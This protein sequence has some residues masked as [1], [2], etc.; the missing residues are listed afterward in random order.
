LSYDVLIIGGA[1]AGLTAA[2]YA[3]RQGLKTLVI[4]KDIGGQA[5][6]TNAIENYP[7]FE[8]IGGFELM[9]KFEQQARNFGTEFAYEEVLSITEHKEDNGNSGFIIKTN[10]DDNEYSGH[11]LI[12]AFGKTPRDLNVKGEKEL[13]GRGVSYCA[14][15][16]GPFFKN[17]KVAIVGAGDQ[18]LEAA[19]YLKEL[20]SQLYI[21]HS[22]DQPVGSEES[23]DLLLQNKHNNTNKK[24]SFISNSI[25]KA[26]NG[27]SK[28][29]SLT[30]YDS[31]TKS[32]SKLDVDGIFVELGYIAKTDIVKDLVKLNAS[33]E[34]IVDKYC[35]TSTK[36]IFAAGDVTDVPYKQAIISAGQGAIAALSAYNYLQRLKGKPAIRADWKSSVVNKK[37][38]HSK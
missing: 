5:L 3:S 8:H 23:I 16:D 9:Q 14:V 35:S 20:A 15:C 31:K 29:E 26:I 27:I 36:G 7:P 22:M 1:S 17:K 34:I 18:A 6:L 13:S 28:V 24:I 33:K 4:T 10:N 21:I 19:L 38:R 25:V 12:L 37:E 30:L 11:A 2:T 32:E